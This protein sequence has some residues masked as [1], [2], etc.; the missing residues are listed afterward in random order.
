MLLTFRNARHPMV[1]INQRTDKGEHLLHFLCRESKLEN[2]IFED[3]LQFPS[4]DVKAQN[5]HDMTTPLHYFAQYAMQYLP[6]CS[7]RYNHSIKCAH[8]GYLFYFFFLL[9]VK[10]TF[11]QCWSQP[12]RNDRAK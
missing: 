4:I 12:Q 8:I 7:T 5:K 2:S 3:L 10:Q 9:I 1:D 6:N 11:H